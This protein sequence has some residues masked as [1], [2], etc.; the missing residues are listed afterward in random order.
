MSGWPSPSLKEGITANPYCDNL[1]LMSLDKQEGDNMLSKLIET[2]AS[3]G[4]ELH[5]IEWG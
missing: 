1:P 4:F 3:K 2:F 5:E